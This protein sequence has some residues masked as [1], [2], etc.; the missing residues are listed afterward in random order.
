MEKYEIT[1]EQVLEIYEA[2]STNNQEQLE[3]WFPQAFQKELEVG[4]I[5]RDDEGWIFYCTE[6]DGEGNMYGYGIMRGEYTFIENIDDLS[7]YYS[8]EESRQILT[9]V[10]FEEW[11]EAITK[12][13]IRRYGEN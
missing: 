12:E 7:C 8:N 3:K 10:N 5:Y 9:E 4:K 13:L 2:T 11:K 1:K 6:I